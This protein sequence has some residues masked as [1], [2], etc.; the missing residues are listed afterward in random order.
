M[1]PRS[2][3]RLGRALATDHIRRVDYLH[4][5]T[6]TLNEMLVHRDDANDALSPPWTASSASPMSWGGP[7]TRPG[8]ARPREGAP[9]RA[10]ERRQGAPPSCSPSASQRAERAAAEAGPSPGR[11]PSSNRPSWA[12]SRRSPAPARQVHRGPVWREACRTGGH[13][14]RGRRPE[15]STPER[16]PRP[17]RC[18]S[19]RDARPWANAYEHLNISGTLPVVWR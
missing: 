15:E 3:P 14:A 9:R 8:R 1:S 19:R 7:R 17:G 16:F 18:G 4:V 2:G 6:D 10:E 5:E 11:R 13:L 12:C